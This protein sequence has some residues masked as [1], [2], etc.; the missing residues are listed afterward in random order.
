MPRPAQSIPTWPAPIVTRRW[1]VAAKL[2]SEALIDREERAG[3]LVRFGRR[4]GRGEVTYRVED[5]ERWLAGATGDAPA[6][7]PLPAPSVRRRA[8]GSKSE[9]LAQIAEMSRGGRP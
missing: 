7:A 1:L 2:A 6:S 4:G 3:R 5:V 8:G 9:A